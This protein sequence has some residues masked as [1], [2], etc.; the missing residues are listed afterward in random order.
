[1]SL[2]FQYHL[3]SGEGRPVLVLHGTGGNEVSLVPFARHIA[4]TA[5]LL[6]VRGK[7]MDE[8]VPRF[9]RRLAEGVFDQEDL[10]EKTDELAQFLDSAAALHR[11]PAPF[12]VIGYSNGAN[13]GISLLLRHPVLI[14][15]IVALRAM[16]PFEPGDS[17]RLEGHRVLLSSGTNDPIVKN[18]EPERLR[19]ILTG[20]GAEAEIIWQSTG[21]SLNREEL[22]AARLWFSG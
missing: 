15:D 7:S 17:P 18:E 12:N 5:T 3:D 8:G 19:Q 10:R 2:G 4:P 9:F 1:M 6:S 21:H 13:M 16:V 14:G 20:L 22:D 11:L